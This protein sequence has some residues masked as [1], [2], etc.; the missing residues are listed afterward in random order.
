MT[1]QTFLQKCREVET[2]EIPS[3]EHTHSLF[4]RCLNC[5][6][7]GTDLPTQFIEAAICG[8][9]LS[10]ETVKYYPS[11]CIVTDRKSFEQVL[12]KLEEAVEVIKFYSSSCES[13]FVSEYNTVTGE[14]FPLGNAARE[15]LEDVNPSS[16]S[17]K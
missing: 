16:P 7:F 8:N 14:T 9:C 1:I 6:M 5:W 4:V 13:V 11:C 15:F 17:E 12:T 3:H 2:K 10:S